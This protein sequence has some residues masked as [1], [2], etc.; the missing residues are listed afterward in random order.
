M[1]ILK[2]NINF[3]KGYANPPTM[4]VLVDKIPSVG[5]MIYE[6]RAGCYL[7]EKDGY[8][9]FFYYDRPGEGYGGAIFNRSIK[10]DDGTTKKVSFKGPWSSRPSAMNMRFDIQCV[11]VSIT[12]EPD[13]FEKGYTFMSG[14][15]T[16]ELAKEAIG[17]IGG[18]VLFKVVDPAGETTYIPAEFGYHGS[19]I[20]VTVEHYK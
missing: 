11:G 5:D 6:E 20:E 3:K 17:K 2:A 18:V 15:I 13:V 19:D 16:L 10:Q 4:R 9:N 7:A 12:D 1:E 14:A 8:V